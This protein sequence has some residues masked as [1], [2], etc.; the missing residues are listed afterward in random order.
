MKELIR[1]LII[2]CLISCTNTSKNKN[3]PFQLMKGDILFQ[4]LDSSPL[5]DA[6]ELV[7]PG[8]K[9]ANL[10]HIGIVSELGDPYCINPQYIFE[11]NIRILEAI[12]NKV[13]TTRL[14][15]FLQRS[16]NKT[17]KPK[18][19]VGRL[20]PKY[21]HTIYDAIIFLKSKLNIEYDNEFLIDNNKY[22]C[23]ELIY[24]AFLKDSIFELQYMT[25]L[26]PESNDT[27]QAWSNYYAKLGAKIPQNEL[28]IN[29]G[30]MSLSEKIEIVHIYG[31]PDGMKK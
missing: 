30:I 6:I 8:Y 25:F 9:E 20:K 23:S 7:T 17:N 24:E 21:R 11:D 18:V 12:P 22:Y 27:L 1:L 3:T 5:C 16:F 28:G 29:P 10:S 15:S 13:K 14:D 31:S 4:D 19:I 26:H 2:L